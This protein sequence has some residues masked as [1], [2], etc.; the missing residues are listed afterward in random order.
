MMTDAFVP[1]EP[2]RIIAEARTYEEL[3]E[4]L[5]KWALDGLR[6]TYGSVEELS[7]LPSGYAAK[8]FAP[9]PFRRAGPALLSCLLGALG[10]KICLAIDT[11]QLERIKRHSRFKIR[12]SK[13]PFSRR[14]SNA[15][16]RTPRPHPAWFNSETGRVMRARGMLK[17]TPGQRR[18]WAKKAIAA[19][20]AK[21]K[22]APEV[23]PSP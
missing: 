11:E 9:V 4:S 6:M 22:A 14:H 19:R 12:N 16:I 5:R 17:T 7:G 3:I 15:S 2:L 13:S 18:K 10:L 23:Q 8:I 20:W 1:D 21:N